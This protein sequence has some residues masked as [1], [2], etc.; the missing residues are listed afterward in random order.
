MHLKWP[1]WV[2]P[3]YHYDSLIHPADAYMSQINTC[4]IKEGKMM[5]VNC[6]YVRYIQKQPHRIFTVKYR[7]RPFIIAS[8]Y[9]SYGWY[10]K[11]N[12]RKSYLY[13]SR[14]CKWCLHFFP[15]WG[16]VLTSAGVC[17]ID[18][19]AYCPKYGKVKHKF[20]H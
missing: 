15:C 14:I 3:R 7:D 9:K 2:V 1:A 17:Y 16:K 18:M 11:D 12:D 10:A 20:I 5:P 6:V 13:T 19:S 8:P 4:R